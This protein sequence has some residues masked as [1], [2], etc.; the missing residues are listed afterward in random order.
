MLAH[1]LSSK[2]YIANPS[3]ITIKLVLVFGITKPV[4]YEMSAI[5][6]SIVRSQLSIVI[7]TGPGV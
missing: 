6:V 5:A 3:I 2:F 4:E 1:Q 7:Q